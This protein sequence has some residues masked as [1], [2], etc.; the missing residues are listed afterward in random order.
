[1]ERCLNKEGVWFEQQKYEQ[2]EASYQQLIA[3][4]H[5]GLRVEVSER[6]HSMEY[7]C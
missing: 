6:P 7:V 4:Q 2:A 1:M 5:A 3:Q